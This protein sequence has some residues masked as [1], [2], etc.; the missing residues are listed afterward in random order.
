MK[1]RQ[2]FD[3]SIGKWHAR[4][5]IAV[6]FALILPILLM[7]LFGIIDF[8]RLLYTQ[9][10][11]NTAVREGA[12]MG[13]VMKTV[14]VSDQEIQAQVTTVLLA[15]QLVEVGNVTNIPIVRYAVG[16][17]TNLQVVVQYD[18]SFLVANVFIP[19]LSQTRAMNATSIM[20]MEGT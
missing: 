5:S 4:G 17:S 2:S 6:E 13:I 1:C 11:L 10:V 7:L 18:F 20:R 15:S 16:T 8:G 9:E 14:P 19:G 12:R 3:L